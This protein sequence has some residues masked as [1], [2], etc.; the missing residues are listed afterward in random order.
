LRKLFLVVLFMLVAQLVFLAAASA[1]E[2]TVVLPPHSISQW[3]KPQNKRQVWLH[4]MFK[5]RREMQAVSEY[6][7]TGNPALQKKWVAR[8][9][10]HYRQIGEMVPEWKDELELGWL[11][12]FESAIRDQDKPLT[13]RA[14][15]KL[16]L[17][18]MGCHKEFRAVTALAYR[19]PDFSKL[20]VKVGSQEVAYPEFMDQLSV[21][22]NRIKIASEDDQQSLALDAVSQLSSEI[23]Q[24]STS[25]QL[26]HKDTEPEERILG[27]KTEDAMGRLEGHIKA[28]DKKQTG[29]TLGEVAVIVCARCHGIHRTVSAVRSLVTGEHK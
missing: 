19:V 3:Y 27:D 10:K 23:T 7:V 9:S 13:E 18:C 15:K 11:T 24:L 20:K 25:C 22:V 17:S 6:L 1:N 26:C 14:I 2:Q 8:F 29:R 4:N 28:G 21:L 5:L 12:R 16:K